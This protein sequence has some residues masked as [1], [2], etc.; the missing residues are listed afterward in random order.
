M[1]LAIVNEALKQL[2]FTK[3][4]QEDSK[5]KPKLRRMLS[6]QKGN[7]IL[8]LVI[9]LDIFSCTLKSIVPHEGQ[10]FICHDL[11][12]TLQIECFLQK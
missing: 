1:I 4:N 9:D 7:T 5:D 3:F 12:R 6:I 11:Y 10:L 8:P 2:K